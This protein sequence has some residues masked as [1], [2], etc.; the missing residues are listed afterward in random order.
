MTTMRTTVSPHDR[1]NAARKTAVSFVC[2]WYTVDGRAD[3]GE[4]WCCKSAYETCPPWGVTNLCVLRGVMN[5]AG[6]GPIWG[7]DAVAG[8][9]TGRT[10]ASGGAVPIETLTFT[11]G[12]GDGAT[13]TPTQTQTPIQTPIQTQTAV[14]EG[15][16][17]ESVM[18]IA[19]SVAAVGVVAV[20]GTVVYLMWK[21]RR[22]VIVPGDGP[23]LGPAGMGVGGQEVTEIPAVYAQEIERSGGIYEI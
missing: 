16:V 22:R 6:G 4:A 18:P 9:S 12:V 10:V 3:N 7:P 11:V 19:F 15:G 14:G 2:V 20:I 21:R 8:V 13:T 17:G 23:F 1:L 5:P